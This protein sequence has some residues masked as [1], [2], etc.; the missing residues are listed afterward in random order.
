MPRPISVPL[1]LLTLAF[2]A[3]FLMTSCRSLPGSPREAGLAALA[4]AP[5]P[6]GAVAPAPWEVQSRVPAVAGVRTEVH[7]DS[8]YVFGRLGPATSGLGSYD[9]S[10]PGG[11]MLQL[12]MNTD[13]AA[14]G[15]S[16]RGIDYLVRGGERLGDGAFVVRRV[17]PDSN[18]PAGWGPQSGEARLT[19]GPRG[20]VLA[21]PLSA[22]GDDDGRLD[23]VLET[24]ATVACPECGGG[25]THEWVA[26]YEG[27]TPGGAIAARVSGGFEVA[28][29]A[30]ARPL[31]HGP[32]S[33]DTDARW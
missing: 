21:V 10:H 2:A 24:Y 28:P 11:W 33:S 32:R 19:T 3:V 12:L 14:T 1:P 27:S 8:L 15:Y 18:D 4:P 16:W 13:Q 9:P 20:F 7:G 29:L 26:S 31:P 17:V 22:I 5:I 6:G 25:I 30:A 23:F